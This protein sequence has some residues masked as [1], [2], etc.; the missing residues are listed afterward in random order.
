DILKSLAL[1]IQPIYVA[2]YH[3]AAQG[4]VIGHDD[5]T[6]RILSLMAENKT[7]KE[8]DR[9]GMFTTGI[10][11][12]YEEYKIALF[13]S[14]RNHSGENMDDLLSNRSLEASTVIRM[15]DAL[16]SNLKT[17][18]KEYL[19]NCLS[20]GRRKFFEIHKFFE[21]ESLTVLE[22]LGKVYREDAFTKKEKMS[23]QERLEHHQKYSAPILS[24]LKDWFDKQF[25]DKLVEP[26][27]S[28]GKAIQY[29]QNHWDGLTNFL[30]I[31]GAPLDNNEVEGLLKV[32]I[33]GRK[34]SLFYKTE[35]GAFIGSM[36]TSIIQ[37]CIMNGI[38]PF[39]YL[40]VLQKNSNFLSKTPEAWLPWNYK[41]TL[42]TVAQRSQSPP[43]LAA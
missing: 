8:K 18:F 38:N 16:A 23:D 25:E 29:M 17:S 4:K 20:H 42:K 32:I 15:C 19:L 5:T 21:K 6:V 2:L 41:E 27:S 30:R 26:N 11:S 37:T 13:V 24:K 34:N 31:A 36:L 40:V 1:E 3:L 12:K 33:R 39:E 7:L 22:A 43:I 9:K 14:G 28:L 35:Y 10:L